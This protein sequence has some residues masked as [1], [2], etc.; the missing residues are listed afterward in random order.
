MK[1]Y[2]DLIED[3]ENT[4]DYPDDEIFYVDTKYVEDEKVE[5][6]IIFGN[7]K[8][9]FIKT[10]AD[11]NLLLKD[12]KY[13]QMAKRVH[14]KIGATVICASNPFAQHEDIDEQQIRWVI[15]QKEFSHFELYFIGVSDGAYHNLTLAKCF[16]ETMKFIGINTSF[17][18]APDLQQKLTALPDVFKVLIYG[19]KDDDFNEVVPALNKMDC[20]N[21]KL[22]FVGGADHSFTGMEKEFIALTDNFLE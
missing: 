19:T 17:I 20:A 11:T 16:P 22:M 9:V 3:T 6:R 7:E 21:L 8:I 14:K 2:T 5:Y 4:W 12:N 18:N 15:T 1:T 13:L 10:G